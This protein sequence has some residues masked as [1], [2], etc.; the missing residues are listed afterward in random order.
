LL[1]IYIEITTNDF[2]L[3]N[4][5]IEF[6]KGKWSISFN[7]TLAKQSWEVVLKCVIVNK[8]IFAASKKNEKQG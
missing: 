7:K 6:P 2:A 8:F 3:F 5:C 4:N 1:V